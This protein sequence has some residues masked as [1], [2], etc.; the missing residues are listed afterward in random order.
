MRPGGIAVFMDNLHVPR[1]NLPIV[2]TDEAGNTYQQRKLANGKEYLV[3]KN[4]PSSSFIRA[5]IGD[6]VDDFNFTG[7]QYYWIMQCRVK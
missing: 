1:S 3:I 4:F 2:S 6:R 5:V 7:L